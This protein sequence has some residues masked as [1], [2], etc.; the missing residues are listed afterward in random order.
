MFSYRLPFIGELKIII[1]FVYM[2]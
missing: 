1:N 2:L